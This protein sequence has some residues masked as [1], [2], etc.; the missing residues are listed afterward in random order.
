[1]GDDL[2]FDNR[3]GSQFDTQAPR[4]LA[5]RMELKELMAAL[6]KEEDSI[7]LGGGP[8][9]AEAQRAKGRLTVR[10]RL[11]LLLDEG[12]EILELGLWALLVQA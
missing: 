9:A 6:G 8:K 7:R 11:S 1:M 10:E 2:K 5:N 12:T 3:L 4:A